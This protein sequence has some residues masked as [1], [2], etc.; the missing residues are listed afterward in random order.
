ML[1]LD[2]IGDMPLDV[3]AK[4]LRVLQENEAVPLGSNRAVRVDVRIVA[5]T[6]RDLG[7]AVRNGEFRADLLYRLDVLSIRLPP[8]RER[9]DDI[10]PL[11][12]LFLRR[13]AAACLASILDAPSFFSAPAS[14]PAL[15]EDWLTQPLPLAIERLERLMLEHAL[16]QAQGNRAE[17]ARR[18]G[19][20][21]QLLYRKLAQYGIDG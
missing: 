8:L 17:A 18:L 20:H 3:Q 9:P 21:R 7:A 14:T 16:V 12:E 2:E 11:A 15:P 19:I 10:V 5:A 4:I 6:H 13:A 1:L